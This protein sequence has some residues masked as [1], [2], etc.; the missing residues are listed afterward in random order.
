LTER[1]TGP[2][3]HHERVGIGSHR[4][5]SPTDASIDRPPVANF[6]P[7]PET[8]S[9]LVIPHVLKGG[10]MAERNPR[11]VVS[12]TQPEAKY[13]SQLAVRCMSAVMNA[14]SGLS[15]RCVDRVHQVGIQSQSGYGQIGLALR[16][17]RISAT[18]VHASELQHRSRFGRR[19]GEVSQ[20]EDI[21][22]PI[23]HGAPPVRRATHNCSAAS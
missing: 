22:R 3:P 1:R 15:R 10:G 11:G 20:L 7:E 18:P 8:W 12:N 17:Q 16:K 23:G 9:F 4:T 6:S 13:P 14:P 5:S 21:I 19:K 2:K